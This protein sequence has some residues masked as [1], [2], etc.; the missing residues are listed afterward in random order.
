MIIE[1][2]VIK[3][4]GV[5]PE[6]MDEALKVL[7][8]ACRKYGHELSVHVAAACG[9][10]IDSVGQPLPDESLAVCKRVPAV[11][12]GN[13]GLKKYQS[14]PL[15]MRPETAL[16]GIRKALGVTTNIRP[17]KYYPSLASF[18]PL[19]ESVL[20]KGLD[21]VFVRDIMG[22]VFCSDKVRAY[23]KHGDEAY[24]FE[25]YN[26]KIIKATAEIAFR[27]AA[28]RSGRVA[29]LD[30]SNVLESSKLWRQTVH[31]TK[32]G[33]AGIQLEDYYIDNAA[34]RIM[35]APESF[36]VLVT[37]NLF[38]DI[39]SDEGTQMTGTPYLYASAELN[40]DN[41]GIYTPNQLH[42][43]DES[44]SGKHEVN[45]IGM[46]AAAALMLRYTFGLEREAAAIEAAIDRTLEDGYSTKDIWEEGRHLLSTEQMGDKIAGYVFFSDRSAGA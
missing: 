2:A 28:G 36:D 8:A 5:G 7:R 10:T 29:N 6:M 23:G 32:E 19:K 43:P 34:M 31:K 15:N 37:S 25:Y 39:I 46:I 35:A 30:K 17:V 16:M 22:G 13:T 27:L 4:D 33:H 21:V 45:P 24:E 41:H 40:P 20:E 1:I 12:F 26:E 3:G 44:I 42:H 11:L 38:G 9:E 14:L 18:S